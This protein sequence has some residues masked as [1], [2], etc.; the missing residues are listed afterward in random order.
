MKMKAAQLKK[1]IGRH[2]RIRPIP[3]RWSQAGQRHLRDDPWSL[4]RV[5]R[6]DVKITNLSTGQSKELGL[7][8]VRDYRR[9]D[10]LVLHC[11]LILRDHAVDI[12]R[13]LSPRT[14]L[15]DQQERL[16]EMLAECQTKLGVP[17]LMISR[18]GAKL[19]RP[20]KGMWRQ[21][22]GVN[23][24]LELFGPQKPKAHGLLEFASIADSM[25]GEYLR[26][27]PETLTVYEDRFC[28]A[29]TA[30]GFEYLGLVPPA[31]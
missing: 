3:E 26:R 21:V 20:D 13:V 25:P 27:I 19:F 2:F 23:L 4:D 6:R 29:V 24:G 28:V 12:E 7:D 8:N 10:F 1:D 9:P 22:A 5:T 31:G 16:L 17:K 11:Q 18:D 15:D 30:E 14:M